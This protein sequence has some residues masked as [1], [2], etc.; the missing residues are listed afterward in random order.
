MIGNNVKIL[1]N[2]NNVNLQWQSN[3]LLMIVSHQVMEYSII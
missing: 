1:L 2:D 3:D